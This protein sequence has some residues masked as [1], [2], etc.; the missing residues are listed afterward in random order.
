MLRGLI[1]TLFASVVALSIVNVMMLMRFFRRGGKAKTASTDLRNLVIFG[2]STERYYDLLREARLKPT[3]FD[4][5]LYRAGT[6]LRW[7]LVSSLILSIVLLLVD[8]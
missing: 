7:T 5:V 3:G 1:I 4:K 2:D 8:S 6:I